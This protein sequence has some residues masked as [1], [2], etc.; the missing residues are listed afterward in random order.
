MPQ[1]DSFQDFIHVRTEAIGGAV[2][3][4][5]PFWQ[6]VLQDVSIVASAITTVCGAVLGLH[7]V[8]RL[9]RHRKEQRQLERLR[10]LQE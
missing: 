5:A 6:I 4:T 10:T 1:S 2:L 3:M 9:W 7:A 8:Y